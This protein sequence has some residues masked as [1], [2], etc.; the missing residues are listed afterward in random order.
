[1]G[2]AMKQVVVV[3]AVV[4]LA[5][6]TSKMPSST[7]T[8]TKTPSAQVQISTVIATPEPPPGPRTSFAG[9]GTYV[10]GA[11]IVPGTYR[12]AGGASGESC[13]WERMGSLGGGDIIEN[14]RAE[15]PQVVEISPSDAGFKT[16]HCATWTKA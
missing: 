14:E 1:M 16:K 8:V 2:D 9:D 11:D 12:S 3:L 5:G 13:Y 4:V 6:C 7:V 10:V 15:G